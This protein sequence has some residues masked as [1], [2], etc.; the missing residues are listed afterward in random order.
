MKPDSGRRKGAP[1]IK[2]AKRG[3]GDEDVIQDNLSQNYYKL[4]E[5]GREKHTHRSA[6][7]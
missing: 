4:S 7:G 5:E 6:S 2:V 3:H 1:G